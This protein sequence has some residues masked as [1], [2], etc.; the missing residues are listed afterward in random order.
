MLKLNSIYFDIND[1]CTLSFDVRS[2]D[3][4]LHM[5]VIL[6]TRLAAV[7]MLSGCLF[8]CKAHLLWLF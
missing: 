2:H 6:M 7:V 3:L 8:L 5:G 4:L 1:F